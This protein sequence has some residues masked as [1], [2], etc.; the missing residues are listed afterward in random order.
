MMMMM[1]MMMIMMMMMMMRELSLFMGTSEYHFG[2][3]QFTA[4]ADALFP[5]HVCFQFY[6]S[7]EDV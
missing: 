4:S 2:V 6:L 1:I 7:H 3:I 5:T